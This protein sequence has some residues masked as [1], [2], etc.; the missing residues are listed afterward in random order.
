MIIR[1][2]CLVGDEC[3]KELARKTVQV[4]G[5]LPASED[6]AVTNVVTLITCG[7]PCGSSALA[8]GNSR[9]KHCPASS[10]V[11]SNYK[12]MAIFGLSV[13][14]RGEGTK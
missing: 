8:S 7:T 12:E 11:C 5:A 6:A 14:T 13:G 2:P 9:E 10:K 1:L 3:E 4:I